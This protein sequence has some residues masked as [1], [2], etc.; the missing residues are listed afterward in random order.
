MTG[1]EGDD[2]WYRGKVLI[3]LRHGIQQ[4][5]D[6]AEQLA[7]DAIVGSEALGL[8]GRL[9]AISAELDALSF[10]GH[11]PRKAHNDPLWDRPPHPFRA[12]GSG[13]AGM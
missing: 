4:S 13:Q 11:D 5:S 6:L 3:H 9:H 1:S 8:L 12:S 7:N 2:T 10:S